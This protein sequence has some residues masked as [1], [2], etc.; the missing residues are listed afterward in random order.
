MI[1]EKEV[2]YHVVLFKLHQDAPAGMK[3]RAFELYQQL[4]EDTG[5]DEAG[6]LYFE[7]KENMDLRKGVEWVELAVFRNN[8][9]LQ[10]FRKH[11]AHTT[12]ADI[13]S[14]IGDWFVGDFM[15]PAMRLDLR[16][17]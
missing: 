16:A 17:L 8:D 7:L 14:Q 9:A 4:K 12:V 1:Q 11:P 13:M 3:K 10:A 6:V 15:S 5:G 2:L